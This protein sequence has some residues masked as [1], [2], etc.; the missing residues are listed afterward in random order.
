MGFTRGLMYAGAESVVI[1]LWPVEDIASE[2]LFITFWKNIAAGDRPKVA[3]L[4]AKQHLRTIDESY[5][6][7]FY[8]AGF[9]LFGKG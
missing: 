4:K 9:V 8:W 7:P 2:H 6:N 1:S 3:L 5:D